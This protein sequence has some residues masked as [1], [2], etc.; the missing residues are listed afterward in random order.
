M[1]NDEFFKFCWKLSICQA[2]L[3]AFVFCERPMQAITCAVT[4][5]F[6]LLF[7]V[8]HLLFPEKTEVSA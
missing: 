5:F 6:W 7:A 2:W 8:L 3:I 4:A 1:S